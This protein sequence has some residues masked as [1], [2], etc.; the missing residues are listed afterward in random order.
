MTLSL[1]GV[2]ADAGAMW[3]SE[4]D[5]LLRVAAVF[6]FLPQLAIALLI[7]PL[8]SASV[9]REALGEAM[10]AWYGAN[11]HWF[12]L[13]LVVQLA[14]AGVVLGLLLDPRRP[15]V[16]EA[17][18]RALRLLPLLTLGMLGSMLLISAGSFLLVVPGLYMLGRTAL[19]TAILV[20]E[21]ERGFLGGF[22]AALE[23]THGAGWKLFVALA[24]IWIAGMVAA[25]LSGAF[26]DALGPYGKLL[27]DAS[28]ALFGTAVTMAQV[29]VQAAAY[30][31][32]PPK[33]GI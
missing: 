1:S 14:G 26:A 29:M 32:L 5:L 7:P 8:D 27:G 9:P 21:P 16:G 18:A 20:A 33:Q 28:V 25:S 11:L 31:A 12:V 3:R 4:R 19:V 23:R 17:I 13:V 15:S 22:A 2:F 30:R 24:S 10:I 6:L